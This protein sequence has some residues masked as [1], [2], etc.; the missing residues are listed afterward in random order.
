[1]HGKHGWRPCEIRVC[2]LGP[3]HLGQVMY[4]ASSARELASEHET[5]GLRFPAPLNSDEPGLFKFAQ[6]SISLL[7]NLSSTDETRQPRRV[8]SCSRF[9]PWSSRRRL[10]SPSGQ[11]GRTRGGSLW[12]RKGSLPSR[13][14]AAYPSSGP[15]N[16]SW[17]SSAAP[18][19]AVAQPG[20]S[21]GITMILRASGAVFA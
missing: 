5:H 9:T 4:G 19:A 20:A 1:M 11:I 12:I 8:P 15:D 18:R 6:P 3:V 17:C 13:R 7:M 21:A 16:G 10:G 2:R 14:T